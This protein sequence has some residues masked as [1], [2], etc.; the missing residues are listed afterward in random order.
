MPCAQH[1]RLGQRE[2]SYR[3]V[4]APSLTDAVRTW[5][6][7]FD[8]GDWTWSS[9]DHLWRYDFAALPREI[10]ISGLL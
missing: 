1:R 8:R 3:E 5:V 4:V 9:D 2:D 7:W 10:R 6:T